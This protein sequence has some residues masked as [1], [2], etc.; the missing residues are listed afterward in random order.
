MGTALKNEFEQ[1]AQ[2]KTC[3]DPS[4]F[5]FALIGQRCFK[6]DFYRLLLKGQKTTL[7]LDSAFHFAGIQSFFEASPCAVSTARTSPCCLATNTADTTKGKPKTALI[8]K[9]RMFVKK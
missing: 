5:L 7:I 1:D 4:I 6:I 2:A 9:H 8:I 3:R